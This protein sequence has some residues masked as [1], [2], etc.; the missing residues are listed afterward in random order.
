MYLNRIYSKV[1]I[2]KHLPNAFSSQNGLKRGDSL[3]SLLLNF[4]L[5]YAIM[6]VQENREEEE[7]NGIY[8]LL[9][10]ADDISWQSSPKC[11]I[12]S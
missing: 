3:L 2:A 4:A 9:V 1:H 7:L 8:Q 5:E 6:K 10:Y 11:R 12:K